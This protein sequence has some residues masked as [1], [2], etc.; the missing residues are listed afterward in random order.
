MLT[1]KQIQILT[2]FHEKLF[3]ELTFKQIKKESKQ[4][5]N[6]L[7]QLSIQ[8]FLKQ[9]LLKTKKTGNV[10]TYK[11]NLKNNL[12]FSYLELIN[13]IKIKKLKLPNEIMSEIQRRI[14]KE[15]IFFILGIFGSYAKQK[16]TKKSDIDIM[17]I[18]DSEEKRKKI[19]PLIETIKR[20]ELLKIDYHIILTREYKEMLSEEYE[21]LAK[22][23]QKNYLITYG[24]KNY[25]KLI[26]P[27]T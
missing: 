20:R 15:T 7:I 11:L 24:Y 21:N 2:I 13:Q 23:I 22:Q 8:E 17:I 25:I 10:T 4:K 3:S 26:E 14:Q 5:S 16:Q 12:T 27:K 1:K 18:V 19:T 6:N 9:E